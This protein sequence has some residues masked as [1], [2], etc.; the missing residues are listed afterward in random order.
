MTENDKYINNIKIQ[1]KQTGKNFFCHNMKA[2]VYLP[3]FFV[4][5]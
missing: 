5:T 1:N 4:K 2:F 3:E